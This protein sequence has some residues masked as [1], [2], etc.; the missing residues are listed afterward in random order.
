MQIEVF[1]T[2]VETKE[3]AEM[4]VHLIKTKLPDGKVNFDLE[5]CDN[6]LRIEAKEVQVQPILNLLIDLGF[7]C[8]PLE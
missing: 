5:D 6:I 8:S 2:N 7:N 4:V 3:N 1:K